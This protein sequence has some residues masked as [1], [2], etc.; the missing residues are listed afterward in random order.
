MILVED[1]VGQETAILRFTT[2]R[3]GAGPYDYARIIDAIRAGGYDVVSADS[4]DPIDT[5]DW[6]KGTPGN[7]YLVRVQP[8]L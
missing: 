4:Q 7:Y 5:N 2:G 3:F 1:P 8:G 6:R